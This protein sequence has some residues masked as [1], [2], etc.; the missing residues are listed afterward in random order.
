MS[1]PDRQS[2]AVSTETTGSGE[3]TAAE[4]RVLEREGLL[5]PDPDW[6]ALARTNHAWRRLAERSLSTA[7]TAELLGVDVPA[8]RRLIAERRL[9]AFKAGGRWRLPR[10]QFADGAPLRELEAVLRA[11]SPGLHPL[12]VQG[13]LT[14]PKPELELRGE[15]VDP[16]RWLAAGGDPE[17]VA[18]LTAEL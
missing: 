10:W 13:F 14:S 6:A 4:R 12:A 7:E 5:S 15:R 16:L 3:L 8:V 1:A 2:G 11:L 9:Y 17:P 18:G